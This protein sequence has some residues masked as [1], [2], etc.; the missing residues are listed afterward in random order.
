MTEKKTIPVIKNEL[1]IR[2]KHNGRYDFDLLTEQHTELSEFVRQNK[3][4]DI[5]IDF[6]N[7]TAVKALNTSLLKTY[8]GLV[9]WDIPKDYL[10]PP[11]PGRADYI[12]HIA[13]LLAS[14]NNNSIPT[15]NTITCL[16]IG[17]GANC[18]YP[19]IGNHEYG[20]SF[21]GS[22]IAPSSLKSARKIADKNKALKPVLKTRLQQNSRFIFTGI[23]NENEQIDITICNPPFHTS[24]TAAQKSNL[25][26][27]KNLNKK[28]VKPSLNFG[29]QHNELWCEGGELKFI[30]DMIFESRRFETSCFWFTTLVSKK[31]HLKPIYKTLRKVEASEIKTIEMGQGNKQ[32]RIVA[33]TFLT[34]FQQKE[35]IA[36]W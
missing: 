36:Q 16:D 24:A 8:Y 10:C 12:H 14:S 19:I 26:K 11:I 30:R 32:T 7:P 34:N 21:I 31:E 2:N 15:G 13:D 9:F 3:Y 18:I 4:G 5:S 1:H 29:G 17:V 33:W 28:E 23:I 27:V 22:D 6:A 25:R 35:W 20:W